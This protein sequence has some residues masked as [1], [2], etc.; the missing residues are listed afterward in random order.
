[1]EDVPGGVGEFFV[2]L[3]IDAFI[4]GTGGVD[5]DLTADVV[6]VGGRTIDEEVRSELQKEFKG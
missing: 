1:M 6:W 3:G 2:W 5:F 4:G